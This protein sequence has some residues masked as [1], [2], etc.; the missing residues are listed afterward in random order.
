MTNAKKPLAL[1]L[2]DPAGIGPDISLLAFAAR[3]HE[4]IPPFVLLGDPEVL[5]ARARALDLATPIEVIDDA[6]AAPALFAE[7]LPVLPISVAAAV[8]AGRPDQAA[9][10]AI[11][12]SIE[13]AVALVGR[14]RGECRG[15]QPD[16]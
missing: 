1:T 12:H 4:H 10:P 11:R 16:Q 15:H 6:G 13:R 2:G 14:W 7:A 8:I 5:R 3:R 9:A